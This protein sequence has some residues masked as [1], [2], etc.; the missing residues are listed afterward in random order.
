MRQGPRF[1][2]VHID[3]A[4]MKAENTT[5]RQRSLSRHSLPVCFMLKIGIVYLEPCT[6]YASKY[7]YKR[8]FLNFTKI[9]NH[10]QNI[11]QRQMSFSCT[12]IHAG[13]Q[14]RIF[15]FFLT[16]VLQITSACLLNLPILNNKFRAE[17]VKGQGRLSPTHHLCLDLISFSLP[18]YKYTK[19][20]AI[21]WVQCSS[22]CSSAL[23]LR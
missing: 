4:R 12:F 14:N 17:L 11:P 19:L 3:E 6:V 16:T 7:M 10:Q 13:V 5:T 18:R 15:F 23:N 1:P 21:V 20:F 22:S 8:L 2:T 9:L